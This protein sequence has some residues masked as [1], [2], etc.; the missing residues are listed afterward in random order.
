MHFQLFIHLVD[1]ARLQARFC[2]VM[3]LFQ[4]SYL[5]NIVPVNM[6][7]KIEHVGHP[8][9]KS[10]YLLHKLNCVEYNHFLWI[11][12]TLLVNVVWWWIHLENIF[13]RLSIDELAYVFPWPDKELQLVRYWNSICVS[14][15]KSKFEINVFVNGVQVKI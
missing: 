5:W 9:L 7:S 10:T 2:Q 13:F 1:Y 15:E 3:N 12:W 4:N 14:Y 8:F 6:A 11:F